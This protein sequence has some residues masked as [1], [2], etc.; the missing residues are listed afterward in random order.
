MSMNV[1]RHHR[2]TEN[3][4]GDWIKLSIGPSWQYLEIE[5]AEQLIM[6]LR[7]VIDQQ[8]A[9]AETEALVSPEI[10][11]FEIRDKA[12]FIPAMA[13]M[14]SR[15]RGRNDAEK[16]LLGSSGY[17]GDC[18]L[19]THLQTNETQHEEY[20]W[21]SGARTMPTAHKFIADNWHKLDSGMVID[22]EFIFVESTSIKTSQRVE[23][24]K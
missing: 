12:T 7:S 3:G 10:K 23:T 6:D 15:G 14:L 19:L 22:V 16:Y 21:S 17:G 1:S 13:T 5:E 8:S 20:N 18:V 2:F 9:D 4:D 24:F 11:F